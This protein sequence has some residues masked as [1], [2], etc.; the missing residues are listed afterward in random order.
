MPA[1]HAK[2]PIWNDKLLEEKIEN[3][4][5]LVLDSYKYAL[6]D[7]MK[8]ILKILDQHNAY[9]EKEAKDIDKIK[10]LIEQNPNV[11][12]KNC[13]NGHITGSALVVDAESKSVLLHF[14]KK[15]DKWLQFGGHCE[16][17][18][19]I[20]EVA[21]REAA[22]ETGL[23]DLAFL[24]DKDMVLP[25]DIDMH[26]IP[27]RKGEPEHPHLDFRYLLVT[28]SA[29]ELSVGD[30]ESNIFKWVKFEEVEEIADKLDP[31]LLRLI[32]KAQLQL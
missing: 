23:K 27:E 17:E 1:L 4:H 7:R 11:L 10:V 2:L 31:A 32:N 29:K 30:D 6:E 19:D 15:L 26:V 3:I 28:H 13:E 12:N 5:Q 8:N 25:L 21:L 20:S 18:T 22:E 16:Y 14:H 9:D 24:S